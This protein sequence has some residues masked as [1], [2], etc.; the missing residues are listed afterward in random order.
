[1]IASTVRRI[2]QIEAT[3]GSSGWKKTEHVT[4][5]GTFWKH[6]NGAHM[7]IPNIERLEKLPEWL[8]QDLCDRIELIAKRT[9]P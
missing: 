5:T 7:Q 1:M 8:F 6:P 9:G 3:L 2:E 4:R